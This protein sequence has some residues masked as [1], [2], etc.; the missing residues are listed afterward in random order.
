[1]TTADLK[2]CWKDLH[3]SRSVADIEQDLRQAQGA[4]TSMANLTDVEPEGKGIFLDNCARHIRE[5]T[6]ELEEARKP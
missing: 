2:D 5:L 3:Q 1:M 6:A 4:Y